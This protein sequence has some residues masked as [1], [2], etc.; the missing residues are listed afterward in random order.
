MLDLFGLIYPHF[1]FGF[2][3][4]HF[5]VCF[6]PLTIILY[7]KRLDL[8]ASLQAAVVLSLFSFQCIMKT[9]TVNWRKV[10]LANMLKNQAQTSKKQYADLGK[11]KRPCDGPVRINALRCVREKNQSNEKLCLVV[12]MIGCFLVVKVQK[13]WYPNGTIRKISF[14]GC[15]V[16]CFSLF[17]HYRVW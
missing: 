6:D 5:L 14:Y 11:M 1:L 3:K 17:I 4:P 7:L 10:P 12:A 15:Y 13:H 9:V 16:Q 2:K 8:F